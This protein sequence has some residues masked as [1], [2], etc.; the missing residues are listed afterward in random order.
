MNIFSDYSSSVEMKCI[1]P[2]LKNWKNYGFVGSKALFRGYKKGIIKIYLFLEVFW[3][4]LKKRPPGY[5]IIF[6]L[7]HSH[8]LQYLFVPNEIISIKCILSLP[9]RA[10]STARPTTK[11]VYEFGGKYSVVKQLARL[12]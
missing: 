1:S 12:K 6:I 9:L 4:Y 11:N 7:K 5:K 3:P 8:I 2:S 10:T